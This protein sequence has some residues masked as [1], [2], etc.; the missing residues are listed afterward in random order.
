MLQQELDG[1]TSRLAEL[2]DALTSTR[3]SLPQ[4]LEAIETLDAR[5]TELRHRIDTAKQ[6]T[7]IADTKPLEATQDAIQRTRP[8]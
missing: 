2:Q 6:D 7:A 4:V 3:K 1:I 5:A 8:L